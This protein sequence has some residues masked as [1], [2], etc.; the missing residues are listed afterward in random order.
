MYTEWYIKVLSFMAKRAHKLGLYPTKSQKW[1]LKQILGACRDLYND[2]PADR[3]FVYEKSGESV[4]YHD[5]TIALPGRKKENP[6]KIYRRA[7]SLN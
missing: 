1:V 2:S 4:A 7:T 5:Q 3:K 6:L